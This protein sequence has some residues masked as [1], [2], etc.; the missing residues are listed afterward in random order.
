METLT[1]PELQLW[2]DLRHDV[3]CAAGV[4]RR[5]MQGMGAKYQLQPNDKLDITTGIITRAASLIDASTPDK[6]A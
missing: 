3:E 1:T 6:V 4:L 5:F 2:A